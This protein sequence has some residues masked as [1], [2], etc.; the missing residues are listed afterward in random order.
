M[1]D[2]FE[3]LY[4]RFLSGKTTSDEFRKLKSSLNEMSDSE[5]SEKMEAYW[6]KHTDY[7]RMTA[8][9]KEEVRENILKQIFPNKKHSL[10]SWYRVAAAIA[11][12][13]LLS[14][15]AWNISILSEQEETETFLAEVPAG[16]K[17]QLTLPDNS[18]VKLNSES[19]LAYN[20]KEG[21][22]IAELTGEG[23]FEVAK[24]PKHPFVVQ[25]GTLH[26]EV[27]GTHFNVRSYGDNDEIETSLL[28]G[29]I[30]LYDTHF[31]TEAVLLKPSEKAVYYRNNGKINL[32][33]TDNMQ[34][35]AWTRDHLV[36]ES[37]KLSTV[38]LRIERWYGVKIKLLCPEIANDRISGSFKNEQLPYVMEALRM[39]YGFTYEITGNTITINKYNLK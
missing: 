29:S 24:D 23:Y 6:E 26:I 19:K 13:A 15:T 2:W 20:R 22:R 4:T 9:R 38:F 25:I 27:L 35:T 39:Q 12:V 17:V 21:K 16:N 10:F 30:R 3:N 28:E 1:T 18:K 34:E 11:V 37:E 36:F 7:P 33:R 5:L 32:I 8:E 31:P 14:V